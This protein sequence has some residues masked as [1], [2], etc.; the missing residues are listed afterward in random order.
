MKYNGKYFELSED[1]MGNLDI[2]KNFII[3]ESDTYLL[4][5]L[6]EDY[7]KSKGGNSS[8]FVLYKQDDN[9]DERII[10]ISNYF[11]P[12]NKKAPSYIKL[13]Y[14]R[15]LNEIK[16]LQ[17]A[18]ENEYNN[19]LKIEFDG[20][21]ET[22]GM[23]FPYYVMEKADSDLKEFLY[24]NELDNQEKIKFCNEIFKAVKNLHN[25]GYYHRDIK[26][27][28]IFLFYNQD[29]KDKDIKFTWKIG[30]LG[31]IAHRDKDYDDIGERIGPFGWISPEAM[32]KY[33]TEKYTLGFDCKIDDKS[34]IFQLGKLYWFMFMLHC[35]IGQIY[36]KDFNIT[37]EH[38]RKLWRVIIKML[39]LEKRR[40]VN[41]YELEGLLN[42]LT[43]LYVA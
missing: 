36:Y 26:P 1:S 28:N 7:K 6:S 21:L 27:D 5:Y 33:L 20:V 39:T 22:N 4:K 37:L 9:F 23:F 8:I 2:K 30:D 16:A 29:E 35:P 41:L 42:K 38:K 13:R 34:D 18:K 10:K 43:D 25:L 3:H 14:G 32:N 17:G 40:R 11:K 15:F 19:I 31:L 24:E 12:K